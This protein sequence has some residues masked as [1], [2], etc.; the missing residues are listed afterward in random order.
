[1]DEKLERLI[2]RLPD[3]EAARRVV[4]RLE[5]ERPAQFA[6]IRRKPAVLANLATLAAY[7][8]WLGDVML[9]QPD[10]V[11]WLARQRNVERG[12]S[13]E[14]FLEEL[15]RYAARNTDLDEQSLLAAFKRRELARIYLRD[16][17]GLA[18]LTE[19]TEEVSHLADAVLDR[20][21]TVARQQLV[22]R[23]GVPT[24]ADARGRTVDAEFVVVALGK[25]GSRELNYASDI[26]L[27]F[28]Y[29]GAGQTAA[30]GRHTAAETVDNH[31]FFTRLA[32]AVFKTTGAPGRTAP[33]YRV[34]LRL[35]PYGRD[36]EIAVRYERAAEYYRDKAQSWERQM[37]IRARAAAGSAGLVSRLMAELRDTIFRAEPLAEAI[38][39][40]R[41][42]RDKID[43]QE[44]VKS[45]GFNVKLG[46]GG[47]REIEF[48]A[49]ALQLAYGGRDPWIRVPQVLIGLQRLAD[50]GF[51][52]DADRSTLS[53]AYTF[54]RTVEH[55]LQMAQGAQTHRLPVDASELRTL[56]RRCGYDPAAGDPG[57]QLRRDLDAYTARVRTIAERVFALGDRA[58][59]APPT[60]LAP[61]RAPAREERLGQH[62]AESMRPLEASADLLAKLSAARGE[63]VAE[64]ARQG[65]GLLVDIGSRLPHPA[66]ALRDF[67]RYLATLAK[68]DDPGAA[69]RVLSGGPERV[70]QIVRLLG[71]GAFFSEI[72]VT[73]PD[74]A[75]EIPG[76]LFCTVTKERDDFASAFEAALAPETALAGRMAALRRAWYREIVS[77]GAHDVLGGCSMSAVNREQTGLAEASLDAAFRIA[78]DELASD[79]TGDPR[80]SVM[81]LGRLG[82]AGMDYGSDLDLL[83]VFDADAPSPA[84]D[85]EP[86]LFYAGFAQLLVK[87]LSALTRE[88]YVYRVDFR[89][90]PEGRAGRMAS[91][92]GRMADY[93]ATRAS[94]W[95][96]AAYLKVRP[97]SGHV[98]FG[99]LA[100]EEIIARVF[101]AAAAREALGA[102]L[103]DVRRGL[104]RQH[105]RTGRDVKWGRGAMMDVYF[106]TRY[107][108]LR[109]RTDFPPELGTRALV[110]HL[111]RTGALDRSVAAD[112]RDGYALLRRIDHSLRLVGDRHAPRLPEDAALLEEIAVATGHA[113]TAEFDAHFA[114]AT[115]RIRAAFDGVF[116]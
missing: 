83:V 69:R 66:R 79:S 96:L 53:E 80:V 67:E 95:E 109:T 15:G 23:Y 29:A 41:S 106:V 89:L 76:Y 81:A 12:Y 48:V 56:G 86:P 18:T 17:L 90:R 103:L 68:S 65:R 113:T 21:L 92:L 72:L 84:P 7:S 111:G 3:R 5:E 16:C 31:T 100:R 101:D 24:T 75:A 33:V 37:L 98:D 115:S 20:A 57:E 34:D 99:R 73:R 30:T 59:E 104:E 107:V 10:V 6:S 25:L 42:A 27:M 43:R 93:V 63:D 71:S 108:Q 40:V 14:D 19:T 26:D 45:G 38:R 44:K 94:A 110:E 85:R 46:P 64:L 58:P 52:S 116:E 97:V 88:G 49:Q 9:A 70:D 87:V 114:D 36:G 105:A 51:L 39:D 60:L 47:I 4:V 55:R 61:E 1:M 78:L 74:L 77:V 2:E 22:N 112:L 32:E 50:K 91:S 62:A 102:E 82:H 35:R 28:L 8:P 13:K 54:L 11:D